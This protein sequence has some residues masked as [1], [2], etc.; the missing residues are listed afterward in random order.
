MTFLSALNLFGH[1]HKEAAKA[2][3]LPPLQ[4]SIMDKKNELYY[5]INLNT[6]VQYIQQ[7]ENLKVLLDSKQAGEIDF[8]RLQIGHFSVKKEEHRTILQTAMDKYELSL[9]K[10]QMTDFKLGL[11]FAFG[12]TALLLMPL[13]AGISVAIASVAFAAFGYNLSMRH[14]QSKA[15]QQAQAELTYVYIWCMNDQSAI[16]TD[17]GKVL[18]LKDNQKYTKNNRLFAQD[19][20]HAL[21]PLV[22]RLHNLFNPM[23]SDH[24][25]LLYTRNDL[26]KAIIQARAKDKLTDIHKETTTKLNLSL[27]FLLYGQHQGNAVQ[28]TKGIMEMAKRAV[29]G[30]LIT[31]KNAVCFKQEEEMRSTYDMSSIP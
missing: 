24:N 23:L 15:Y 17:E 31:C 14:Q 6:L 3:Q 4:L 30:S 12:L 18:P 11:A 8:S 26:D 9:A 27:S 16:I 20:Y 7:P 22:Q 10:L 21:H 1:T 19:V 5:G 28:I 25:I 2:P 13:T 29:I